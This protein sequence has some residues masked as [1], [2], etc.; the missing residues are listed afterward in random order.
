MVES[1]G[2]N[3]AR[4]LAP[5]RLAC[6]AEGRRVVLGVD[7]AHLLDDASAA[8]L[9]DLVV[10]GAA[11]VV[12]TLRTGEPAPEPVTALWKDGV[13]ERALPAL[14]D[15]GAFHP[16]RAG[17]LLAPF[18]TGGP[19]VKLIL[20]QMAKQ[21]PPRPC[22]CSSRSP[23]L[24]WSVAGSRTTPAS[25]SNNTPASDSNNATDR[26]NMPA[27]APGIYP[28]IGLILHVLDFRHPERQRE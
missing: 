27:A 19:Q 17:H 8:V 28:V 4:V 11:F 26:S 20:I 12:A 10:T 13:A 16:V 23:W 7:D 18:L 24:T 1:P 3:S 9:F 5:H 22:A 2:Q 21:L 15:S 25:D 6:Q 14:L